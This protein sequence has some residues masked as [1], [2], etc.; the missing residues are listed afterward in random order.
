MVAERT[1]L[2]QLLST[3]FHPVYDVQQVLIADRKIKALQGFLLVPMPQDY[4][5]YRWMHV[6]AHRVGLSAVG[7][8]VEVKIGESALRCYKAR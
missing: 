2:F 4:V 3:E 8:V 5:R 7:R 6:T 1:Q